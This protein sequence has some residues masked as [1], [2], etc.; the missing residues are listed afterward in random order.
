MKTEQAQNGV[1]KP[2]WWIN[3]LDSQSTQSKIFDQLTRETHLQGCILQLDSIAELITMTPEFDAIFAERSI[4][5]SMGILEKSIS[6][7]GNTL[8]RK[9]LP[10][11]QAHSEAGL[12]SIPLL[13]CIFPDEKTILDS[14]RVF[15]EQFQDANALVQLPALPENIACSGEL[16]RMG[17]SI[18]YTDVMLEDQVQKI[19][20]LFVSEMA[21]R[22][23]NS[24]DIS[25]IFVYL[26][27]PL[28]RDDIIPDERRL[29]SDQ[30]KAELGY[31]ANLSRI[32]QKVQTSDEMKAL[33]AIGANPIQMIWTDT[34][35]A[36]GALAESWYVDH[37]PA[38]SHFEADLF[39]VSRI[40]KLLNAATSVQAVDPVVVPVDTELPERIENFYNRRRKLVEDT[41]IR[42]TRMIRE[43]GLRH[44]TAH[45]GF[46]I[47]N[48]EKLNLAATLEKVKKEDLISRIWQHDF[49][50][51]KPSPVEISNR[52]GWLHSPQCMLQNVK[53]LESFVAEIILENRY[54][55]VV[56]CGMGGSSLAPEVFQKTFGVK[57]G[58]L[59]LM[60]LD[61]TDPWAMH[62]VDDSLNLENTLFLI[63]TKSGSTIETTS[64]M[65][66]F[67]HRLVAKVGAEQAG[68]Q[69]I[70]I[71]DPGSSLIK[72]AEQY[73]FRK[74]F[75]NDPNIGGRYSA[76]S[77]FGLLPAALIG[78]NVQGL[79]E[80]TRGM[81]T[82][83]SRFPGDDSQ[84]GYLLGA[85]MGQ[86][87]VIG[88]DKLT[89]ILSPS[90][91]SFGGWAE[92]LI[93]ESTGKNGKGILP[94]VGEKVL[95]PR[96]YQDDRLFVYLHLS[97]DPAH[98]ESVQNLIKAGFPVIE[99]EC[100][101]IMELGSQ[102]LLWEFATALAGSILE[103]NPFDQPDVENA[104]IMARTMVSEFKKT[105]SLTALKPTFQQQ[106]ISVFGEHTGETL[107]EIL[108]EYLNHLQGDKYLAIQAYLPP[109]QDVITALT[110]MQT[111]IHSNRNC[112]VTIG[113]G[114]RYLHSTG[115]L[116]KGDR[117]NGVFLQITSD[118]VIDLMI[119]DEMDGTGASLSFGIL[120]M[121]AALGD[122]EVLKTA[123]RPV[124][125][126]HLGKDVYSGLKQI[127]LSLAKKD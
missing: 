110:D 67:Y 71:T 16:L 93:A 41:L 87:A 113:L 120:K 45:N 86:G 23:Q 44:Q 105:G 26:S 80:T 76:L 46:K 95:S 68:Q 64:M 125:H 24:L 121:A 19:V 117:G 63:S 55:H 15:D 88:K 119:P 82:L 106:E 65:K 17:K 90:L 123:G 36:D 114:P 39:Q 60:V 30:T 101:S 37:L 25:R 111:R 58:Y 31:M 103:I 89:F 104:K 56:L 40:T 75:L 78:I 12:V 98:D 14:L 124:L 28:C 84:V 22:L 51:W 1:G 20:N 13:P 9:M 52:L 48:A 118:P 49:N 2:H 70:A 73:H 83:L 47:H 97:G 57:P 77:F 32:L 59:E 115:Q 7:L 66:Y 112:A 43:K 10:L 21:D 96:F 85:A 102:F 42:A 126:I 4:T 29:T 34:Y 8:T 108:V 38:G 35:A 127:S 3:N 72:I 50:V 62:N 6:Q 81:Q 27:A 33:L 99:M 74:I 61:S 91:D 11:H 54:T 94:V 18:H 69:F 109:S 92:Q 107:S 100:A 79:L 122:Q 53:V 116:H 5:S